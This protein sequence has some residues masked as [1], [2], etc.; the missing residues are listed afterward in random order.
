VNFLFP[1][2]LLLAPRPFDVVSIKPAR[3][4]ATMQDMRISLPPGRMEALNITLSELLLSFSGFSG[5]VEGGPQWVKSDRFDIVAKAEGKIPPA[6]LGPM[7]MMLLEDRFKLTVHHE[8]KEESGIVLTKGKQPPVLKT[9]EGGEQVLGRLDDRRQVIFRNVSMPQLAGYLRG[10]LGMPVTDRTGI[11]GSYDF[12]LDPDSFVDTPG[13]AFRDRIRSAVE[14]LG[15]K[16]ESQKVSRD[17]TVI[18]HAE[19]PTEN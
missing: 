14:A 15:F 19:R 3:P 8:T 17:I 5:K 12:S 18:D 11:T 6:E 1:L 2:V 10:M 7:L 9:S 16:L 4:D 13:E